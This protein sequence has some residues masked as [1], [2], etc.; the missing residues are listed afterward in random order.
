[1]KFT[2][3]D[4]PSLENDAIIS[5]GSVYQYDILVFVFKDCDSFTKLYDFLVEVK[6]V[7]DRTDNHHVKE[8]WENLKKIILVYVNFEETITVQY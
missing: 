3:V 2:Y 4:N 7:I 6:E 8:Y 1:M 5:I